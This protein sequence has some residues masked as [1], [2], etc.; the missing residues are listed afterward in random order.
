MAVLVTLVLGSALARLAG[1]LGV[2]YLDGWSN[3]D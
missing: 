3:I 2:D 1:A